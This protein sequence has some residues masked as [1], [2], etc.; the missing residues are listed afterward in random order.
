MAELKSSL[1]AGQ[2]IRILGVS[3]FRYDRL[4]NQILVVDE[5]LA[6]ALKEQRQ[7]AWQDSR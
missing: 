2:N 5:K 6:T 3:N 7:T 4:C 1:D